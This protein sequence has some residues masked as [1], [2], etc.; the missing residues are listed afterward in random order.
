MLTWHGTV[1]T[2][3]STVR[4]RFGKMLYIILHKHNYN[5]SIYITNTLTESKLDVIKHYAP[6][7]Q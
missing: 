3:V 1:H 6:Q 2:Y 5:K 4:I 7:T